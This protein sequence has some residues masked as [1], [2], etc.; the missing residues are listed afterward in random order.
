MII[1]WYLAFSIFIGFFSKRNIL[2]CGIWAWSGSSQALFSVDKFNIL[3]MFNDSRGGDSSGKFIDRHMYKGID[4]NS[5]F[6][7]LITK[8]PTKEVKEN[9]VALGHARKASVGGKTIENAQPLF[10][11]Q[12]EKCLG[13]FMHNGTITNIRALCEKYNIEYNN[14]LSDSYHFGYLLLT[15]GNQILSEYIGSA[16]CMW[17]KWN[18]RNRLYAFKGESKFNQWA[19]VM[20]E[21]RPLFIYKEITKKGNSYWLSSMSESLKSAFQITPEDEEQVMTLKANSVYVIDKDRLS[22]VENIDRSNAYETVSYPAKTTKS[23][24]LNFTNW[25][26]EDDI[27]VSDKINFYRGRYHLNGKLAN[28]AIIVDESGY[29]TD[30]GYKL[31][32]VY[33]VLVRDKKNYLMAISAI[34][35]Y[36]KTDFCREILDFTDQVV[37]DYH[38]EVVSPNGWA[39]VYEA[40]VN[41]YV[42]SNNFCFFHGTF[43]PLFSSKYYVFSNGGDLKSTGYGIYSNYKPKT[44]EIKVSTTPKEETDDKVRQY[45]E[46]LSEDI[47]DKSLEKIKEG[48]KEIKSMSA[49]DEELTNKYVE[50]LEAMEDA[51]YDQLHDKFYKVSQE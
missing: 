25:I 10:I 43:K 17:I 34:P 23:F 36:P 38:G 33:G 44:N 50:I 32:F 26:N 49:D 7:D 20:T 11:Y 1:L 12:N 21:D 42:N 35:T 24:T 9:T 37:S 5:E 30:N 18:N 31:Y 51:A 22:I 15:V 14:E 19:Q 27:E 16:A 46:T 39:R 13:V 48:I 45:I 2:T 47:I 3:G 41:N 4:K 28:G 8:Y 6:K 29:L 40:P